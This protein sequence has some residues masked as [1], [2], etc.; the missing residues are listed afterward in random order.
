MKKPLVY[1]IVVFSISWI[2]VTACGQEDFPSAAPP[3][4]NQVLTNQVWRVCCQTITPSICLRADVYPKSDLL[5][6]RPS[7]EKDNVFIF[8]K[9]GEW[10]LDEGLTQC[11]STGSGNIAG[12]GWL[13]M[14]N[15]DSLS[16]HL[17]NR[18]GDTYNYR[19]L[20][21]DSALMVRRF[22]Y[23]V[24]DTSYTITETLQPAE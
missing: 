20:Y 24:L 16:L 7:C 21:L 23:K 18:E 5:A 10:R 3:D 13:L 22:Q 17:S 9:N 2:L 15:G 4:W 8:E 6:D 14:N 12:G 1:K 19:I 11:T